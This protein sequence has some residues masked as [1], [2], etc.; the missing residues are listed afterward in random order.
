[1]VVTIKLLEQMIRVIT[2]ITPKFLSN[3]VHVQAS[4]N[5]QSMAKFFWSIKILMKKI[6]CLRDSGVEGGRIPRILIG[7]QFLVFKCFIDSTHNVTNYKIIFF[8]TI[9]IIHLRTSQTFLKVQK[10]KY[11]CWINTNIQIKKLISTKI[12]C[13]SNSVV[14]KDKVRFYVFCSS[15]ILM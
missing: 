11:F 4:L 3:T 15:L 9:S 14:L 8:L 5:R 2:P 12:N 6:D 10:S 13:V 7:W 1:M